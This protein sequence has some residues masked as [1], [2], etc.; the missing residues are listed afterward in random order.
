MSKA[1]VEKR[2]EAEEVRMS[3]QE[4]N[5]LL[6]NRERERVQNLYAQQRQHTHGY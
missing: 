1:P 2:E 3:Q 4:I 5:Q 6:A